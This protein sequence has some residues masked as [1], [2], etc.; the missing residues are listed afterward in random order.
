MIWAHSRKGLISGDIVGQEGVWVY[1][2]LDC[3]HNPRMFSEAN[4][5]TVWGTGEIVTLRKSLLTEVKAD[6]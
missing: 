6:A 4:Q 2:K 5:G 1:V 3:D